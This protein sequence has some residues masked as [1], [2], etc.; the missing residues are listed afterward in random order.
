MIVLHILDWYVFLVNNG[1]LYNY[2]N[3][4]TS[5]F[6][7][8]QGIFVVS[9]SVVDGDVYTTESIEAMALSYITV[10]DTLPSQC[11]RGTK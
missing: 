9:F 10:W 7:N 11:G 5:Q 4:T 3:A 6:N 2:G 1:T 8:Q